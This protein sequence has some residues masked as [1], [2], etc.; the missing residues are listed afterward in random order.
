MT[1]G[2]KEKHI[3]AVFGFAQR[4][5]IAAAVPSTYLPMMGGTGLT[6]ELSLL[7]PQDGTL[8]NLSWDC[9][10]NGLTGVNN[11]FKIKV[12]APHTSPANAP[13]FGPDA[14]VEIIDG[15]TSGSPVL[16]FPVTAG[17]RIAVLVQTTAGSGTISR[18]RVSFELEVEKTSETWQLAA[19]NSTVFYDGGNVGIGTTAPTEQLDVN[20]VVRMT[21]IKMQGGNPGDV[22]SLDPAGSG[23][24]TWIKPPAVTFGNQNTAVGIDAL[25]NNSNSG[26]TGNNNTAVGYNSLLN[27][28]IGSYNTAFG[29]STLLRNTQGNRNAA[30]GTGALMLNT[31]GYDN[32]AIGTGA[33]ANNNGYC[34]SALGSFTLNRNTSGVCNTANGYLALFSNINGTCNTAIGFYADVS[35][36]NLTNATAIGY[37]SKVSTSNSLVLGGTGTNAVNVGIGTTSP[38]E[39]LDV[40]G[41]IRIKDGN[42]GAGKVLTSNADGKAY[43]ATAQMGFAPLGS[44]MAWHKNFPNCPS[45]PDEWV[46][47]NGQ[48]LNDPLS[49]F[50][51]NPIPDLNGVT[52]PHIRYFLRGD[53]TSGLT[54]E[55]AMQA[56]KHEE[57]G[58]SH[59]VSLQGNGQPGSY[60]TYASAA[61]NPVHQQSTSNSVA[62]QLGNPVNS[63]TGG[64]TPRIANETRPVNM[65][66]VWI[67]RVR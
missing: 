14:I 5:T 36:G 15:K 17:Q 66:V 46:E 37:N 62:V 35:T 43:W 53:T 26:T 57:A 33:L 23:Y 7:I 24:G 21:R 38:Q 44:I 30:F 56:H 16:N 1:L 8:K 19:D 51:G 55:D 47:C 34:N 67:M 49:P 10:S 22:L 13:A 20:G 61:Y 41:S 40:I 28:T 65:T 12:G 42:E 48:T 54:E 4:T 11:N 45:L 63:G 9:Q 2:Q 6:T 58:H 32:A 3:A 60:G 27:N 31:I 59:L 25:K 39:K 64:G 18:M 29:E 50:N 52:A